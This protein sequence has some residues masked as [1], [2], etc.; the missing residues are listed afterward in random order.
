MFHIYVFVIFLV[1]SPVPEIVCLWYQKKV[2]WELFSVLEEQSDK[3]TVSH[4]HNTDQIWSK[5]EILICCFKNDFNFCIIL[6][7][8]PDEQRGILYITSWN[9]WFHF[10]V[11]AQI[12]T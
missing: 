12:L 1:F 8:F 6:F 7:T 11:F 3:S 5:E 2:L 4:I 10:S 9:S